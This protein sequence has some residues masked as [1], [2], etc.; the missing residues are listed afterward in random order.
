MK[1]LFL[2]LAALSAVASCEGGILDA[3][4]PALYRTNLTPAQLSQAI[5]WRPASSIQTNL[6]LLHIGDSITSGSG[7]TNFQYPKVMALLC[8]NLPNVAGVVSINNG[9]PGSNSTGIATNYLTNLTGGNLA[10]SNDTMF[11]DMGY[12]DLPWSNPGRIYSNILTVVTNHDTNFYILQFPN[13]PYGIGTSQWTN[14]LAANAMIKSAWPAKYIPVV[15]IMVGLFNPLLPGDVASNALDVEPP[16][17]ISPASVNGYP[18]KND[19]GYT[20]MAFATFTNSLA[21]PNALTEGMLRLDLA[22][23]PGIGYSHPGPIWASQLTL[24]TSGQT[25]VINAY[26][27]GNGTSSVGLYISADG[28]NWMVDRPI[29]PYTGVGVVPN[30]GVGGAFP[31][32]WGTLFTS[33]IDAFAFQLQT[34]ASTTPPAAIPGYVVWWNSNYAIY[35]VTPF[36]TNLV[37]GP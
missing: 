34:N 31:Q 33:N 20:Y 16:S 24:P 6:T 29:L 13:G 27:S 36:H 1:K 22:S 7:G 17:L 12:N 26:K 28:F 5:T 18:H 23:P 19:V 35:T 21:A 11:V 9:L 10:W 14:W 32:R 15:D 8:S 2:T 30:L 25:R 3:P 4:I 37:V